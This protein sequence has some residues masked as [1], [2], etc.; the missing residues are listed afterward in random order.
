MSYDYTFKL[1]H[2]EVPFKLN[3]QTGEYEQLSTKPSNNPDV[4]TLRHGSFAKRFSVSWRGLAMLTSKF[5]Y[6]VAGYMSDKVK[7][8][9]N[10]LD[11]MSDDMSLRELGHHLDISHTQVKGTLD[12]LFQLGV[13]GRFD[14]SI[15]KD[16]DFGHKK[17]WVFNPYLTYNGPVV[18]D[19]TR[20]LFSE[21]IFAKL[22]KESD[23][24]MV[25]QISDVLSNKSRS[26]LEL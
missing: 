3:K 5:E 19:R 10:S 14:V 1:R 26:Q 8:I 9:T 4:S 7:P 15:W 24:N 23:L 2:D 25:Q 16:V 6:A 11:P 12:K 21:T 22:I 17:F 13:Y 20:N 18:D